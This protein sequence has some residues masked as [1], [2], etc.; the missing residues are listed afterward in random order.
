LNEIHIRTLGVLNIA[1]G[2]LAGL[3]ALFNILFFGGPISLSG[4]LGVSQVVGVVWVTAALLLMIPC[5]V[6]GLGLISLRGW[7]RDLGIILAVLQLLIIPTGTIIGA[8][9]LVVLFSD[10]AD[11]IFTRRY[12]QYV[13]TKR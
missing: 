13:D 7:A 6:A 4:Y 2:T 1:G 9:G 3:F 5:I 8:Y 12:G 10:T 11:Q